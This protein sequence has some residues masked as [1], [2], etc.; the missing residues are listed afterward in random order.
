MM[1]QL[2]NEKSKSLTEIRICA[3]SCLI[4]H[5]LSKMKLLY[6]LCVIYVLVLMEVLS[7]N[8]EDEK[9]TIR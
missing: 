6:V 7:T 9:L 3:K 4:K 8:L 5:N 2:L 1:S